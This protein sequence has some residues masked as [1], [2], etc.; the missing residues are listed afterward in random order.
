MERVQKVKPLDNYHLYVEFTDG[1]NGEVDLSSRLFGSVF[2]PLKDPDLFRQVTVD[3]FGAV[4][5]PNGA[6]L[7]PDGLYAKLRSKDADAA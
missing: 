5:W 2:E 4:V 1:V 6:D 3:E 7:A